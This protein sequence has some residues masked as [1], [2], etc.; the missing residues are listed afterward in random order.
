MNVRVAEEKLRTP[1]LKNSV[2]LVIMDVASY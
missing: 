1:V 2:P